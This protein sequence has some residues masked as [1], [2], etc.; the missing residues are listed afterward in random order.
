[1]IDPATYESILRK[2]N[3]SL[4]KTKTRMHAFGAQQ[5]LRSRG[6]FQAAVE[7]AK[8]VTVATFYVTDQTTGSLLSY[9]TSTELGI[10]QLKLNAISQMPGA[11]HNSS[12]N[13]DGMTAIRYSGDQFH[14][15]ELEDTRKEDPAV[16]EKIEAH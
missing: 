7:S 13:L 2:A 14:K 16:S 8:K 3:I 1:M 4:S 15:V 9:E 5:P 6:K 10:L 11:N 12:Q